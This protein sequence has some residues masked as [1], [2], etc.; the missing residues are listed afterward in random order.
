MKTTKLL[1]I[2]MVLIVVFIILYL[3]FGHDCLDNWLV[4]IAKIVALLSVSTGIFVSIEQYR[5]KVQEEIRLSKGAKVEADVKLLKIFAETFGIAEC[6]K[7]V[8]ISDKII[9]ELF[10][11]NMITKN[12]FKDQTNL[13]DLN[14]QLNIAERVTKGGLASQITA[15]VS[16]G[17]LGL[18]HEILRKPALIGLNNLLT[19]EFTYPEI[20][21]YI[22]KI[23][24]LKS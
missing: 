12:D 13:K 20:Q 9:E 17:E 22:D 6:R 3:V 18:A 16:V 8:I 14:N 2:L 4:P 5:L 10:A 1:I 23:K 24:A 11:L 15:I 21:E 19:Q 7:D